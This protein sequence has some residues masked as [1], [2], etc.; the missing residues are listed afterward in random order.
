MKAE[1]RHFHAQKSANVL[2]TF[3]QKVEKSA[4]MTKCAQYSQN[5]LKNENVRLGYC[6]FCLVYCLQKLSIFEFY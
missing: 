4:M 5:S 6:K 2:R 1:M 3:D